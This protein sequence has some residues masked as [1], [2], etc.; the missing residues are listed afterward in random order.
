MNSPWRVVIHREAEVWLKQADTSDPRAAHWARVAIET[1]AQYGEEAL[2]L[3]SPP[4]GLVV[5]A[6][7]R[8][9]DLEPRVLRFEYAIDV[10]AGATGRASSDAERRILRMDCTVATSSR[11]AWVQRLSATGAALHKIQHIDYQ[12]TMTD[13]QAPQNTEKRTSVLAHKLLSLAVAPIPSEKRARYAEEFAAELLDLADEGLSRRRQWS[14]A[15]ALILN[16]LALSL[17]LRRRARIGGDN[18]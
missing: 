9:S 7:P 2:L 15:A 12:V 13:R 18:S 6:D 16:G 3:E 10:G 11:T 17:I 4:S 1:L 5:E 14:Y 8:S